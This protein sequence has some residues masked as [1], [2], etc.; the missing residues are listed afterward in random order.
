MVDRV[1]LRRNGA[2]AIWLDSAIVLDTAQDRRGERPWV[3]KLGPH[4]AAAP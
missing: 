1:D 2:T 4:L 3:V